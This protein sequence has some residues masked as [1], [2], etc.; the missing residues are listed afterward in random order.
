M[1]P[2]RR[3][4]LAV[5]ALGLLMAAWLG[6]TAALAWSVLDAAERDAV[7]IVQRMIEY[8]VRQPTHMGR[9]RHGSDSELAQ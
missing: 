8:D 1:R 9:R 4:V 3:L 2:D 5:A 6:A 7:R